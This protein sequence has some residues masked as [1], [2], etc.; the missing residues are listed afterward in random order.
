[1]PLNKVTGDMYGFIDRTWNAVKGKCPHDCS[2]CYMKRWG[3]Q[4][5]VHLDEK[6]LC[7]DLGSGKYIFV[8]SS[9]DMFAHDIP[10]EWIIETLKVME[11]Y[12]GNKY[13]LQT[14]N[15]GRFLEFFKEF[16]GGGIPNITLCTTIET[17]FFIPDIM[18]GSPPPEMRSMAMAELSSRGYRTMVT[19][20]PIL[21]FNMR[22]LLFYIERSNPVQVNI[23]ADS[24]HNHLPE[25]PAWKI[26][27][28][29][30]E[31]KTFTRVVEKN[32][33]RRL[34]K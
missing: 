29:I 28:L 14:K 10:Q 9:C 2:Y 25:P 22:E 5:P 7:T 30:A 20:E 15:P 32:N 33:L 34:L 6:E 1:M 17:N 12:P 21:Y 8:G 18:R 23:G 4:R 19:V 13:L 27:E 24:G 3:K 16:R 11:K 26:R 31:L